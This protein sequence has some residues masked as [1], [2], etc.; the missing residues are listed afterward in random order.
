MA[1]SGVYVSARRA[2]IAEIM[3]GVYGDGATASAQKTGVPITSFAVGEGG[4]NVV[5]G[6]KVPKTPLASRTDTEAT[7]PPA[8]GSTSATGLR[9]T[10][11]FAAG[12]VTDDGAGTLTAV[13]RLDAAEANLDNNSKLTGNFGGD[14]ELFEVVL[15]DFTGAPVAYCTYDEIVKIPGRTVEIQIQISY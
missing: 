3:A 8:S 6:N 5:A 9:F 7:L 10:K 2:R 1:A 11:N 14:P 13:V 15:F 4:Y 12:D